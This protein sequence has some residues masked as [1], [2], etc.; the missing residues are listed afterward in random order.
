MSAIFIY[1]KKNRS[2]KGKNEISDILDRKELG[3][4]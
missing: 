3:Y 4:T 2:V 1:L